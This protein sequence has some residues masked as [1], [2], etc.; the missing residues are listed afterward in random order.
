MQTLPHCCP[1]SP[2]GPTH[3][4]AQACWLQ[5]PAGLSQTIAIQ[6]GLFWGETCGCACP[7]GMEKEFGTHCWYGVSVW[8]PHFLASSWS[9]PL[10]GALGV[11]EDWSPWVTRCKCPATFLPCIHPAPGLHTGAGSVPWQ[12]LCHAGPIPLLRSFSLALGSV[13][14]RCHGAGGQAPAAAL[15]PEVHLC[16]VGRDRHSQPGVSPLP[17]EAPGGA[18]SSSLA[19]AYLWGRRCGG[20]GAG[21]SAPGCSP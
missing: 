21:C 10:P 18:V 1:L 6:L 9:L 13:W 17:R 14:D 5:V 16:R 19:S 12:G 7:Q 4:S 2:L 15:P 20:A 8:C 11:L 3:P